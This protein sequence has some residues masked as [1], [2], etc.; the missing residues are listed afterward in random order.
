[1]DTQDSKTAV[2][3]GASSGIGA[4]FAHKLATQ[5]HDLIRVAEREAR[6]AQLATKLQ[7]QFHVNAEVLAAD[8]SLSGDIERVE[9]R[10][11]RRPALELLVNNAGFGVPGKF[12]NAPLDRTLAMI[13]VHVLATTR[14]T[15]GVLPGMIARGRAE[16]STC[17]Q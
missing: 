10:I 1:M 7:Q 2:I 16:L 6:L 14:L 4:A 9:E 15:H 3:T 5:G 13:N 8:L 11:A 17:L 12:I